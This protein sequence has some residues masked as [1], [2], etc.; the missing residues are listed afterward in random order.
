MFDHTH[1]VPLLRWKRG[2]RGALKWLEPTDKAS[3]TP[4]LELLPG[5]IRPR[6]AKGRDPAP[7]D[8]SVV[9]DQISDSWGSSPIFVD[10]GMVR[11]VPYRG[12]IARNV[13]RF[14]AA[15]ATAGVQAIPVTCHERPARFQS[16]IRE[17]TLLAGNGVAIRV[18]VISLVKQTVGSE[19]R[20]LVRHFGPI[21]E[22][23][24]IIVEYG[25]MTGDAPLFSYVC[26]RLPQV[27]HSRTF[28]V[29]AGSFPPR[30]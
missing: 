18:P 10:T 27:Q 16:A 3:M 26:H 25:L 29:L 12:V 22:S 5:Y 24:D 28:T 17:A 9:V 2:E 23:V 15:L 14:F 30:T 13:E 6:R 1:Y 11:D 19:L 7:D 21:L 20:E 8:L 4:L